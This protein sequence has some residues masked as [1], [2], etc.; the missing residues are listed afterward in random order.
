MARRDSS[1]TGEI[2]PPDSPEVIVKSKPVVSQESEVQSDEK[3][4][5][6]VYPL[7]SYLDGNEVRRAGGKGYT[8]PKHDAVSL[9][10]AGL[11]TDKNPKA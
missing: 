9:I 5:I 2:A 8:S 7:R 11:A 1:A 10:A 4:E 6:T 3:G